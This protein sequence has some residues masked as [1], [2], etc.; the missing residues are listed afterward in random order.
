MYRGRHTYV[1]DTQVVQRGGEQVGRAAD[2]D[3]QVPAEGEG[4]PHRQG[5]GPPRRVRQ[6]Q[7]PA[8]AGKQAPHS[9]DLG[10]VLSFSVS[11]RTALIIHQRSKVGYPFVREKTYPNCDPILLM[12]LI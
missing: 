8:R 1:S 12:T 9:T 10:N 5:R 3:H 7:E 11:L 2:G 6:G 4:D